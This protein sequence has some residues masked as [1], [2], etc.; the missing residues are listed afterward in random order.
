[1][2]QYADKVEPLTPSKKLGSVGGFLEF[3][4]TLSKTIKDLLSRQ[5]S[6]ETGSTAYGNSKYFPF[7]M[8]TG[9]SKKL[10]GSKK[11]HRP[12]IDSRI[13]N[14]YASRLRP[15]LE[16][17]NTRGHRYRIRAIS[18]EHSQGTGINGS[19]HIKGGQCYK[20]SFLFER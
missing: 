14:T 2:E 20:D 8:A 13:S 16:T 3:M 11:A 17:A 1:M 6:R 12:T 18:I 5:V 7:I 10:W 19:G 9:F 4:S 15:Q